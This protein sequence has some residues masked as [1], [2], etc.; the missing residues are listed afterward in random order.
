[1]TFG[2]ECELFETASNRGPFYVGSFVNITYR[3]HLL[4]NNCDNLITLARLIQGG[5]RRVDKGTI[6]YR[7]IAMPL[8]KFFDWPDRYEL[9]LKVFG[10]GNSERAAW[11]A[12]ER[13]AMAAARA[14]EHVT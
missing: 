1:M 10:R 3:D 7:M 4:N 13:G 8:F 2:C 9:M 6:W 11:K 14:T 5:I 12:F